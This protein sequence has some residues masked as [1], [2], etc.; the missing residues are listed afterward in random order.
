MIYRVA[1]QETPFYEGEILTKE[2][3]EEYL[4]EYVKEHFIKEKGDY[5]DVTE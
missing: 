4:E 1:D 2:E 3:L 5:K